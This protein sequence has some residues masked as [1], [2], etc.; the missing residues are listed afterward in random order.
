MTIEF[1]NFANF[2]VRNF[3]VIWEAPICL[4]ADSPGCGK[5]NR[6]TQRCQTHTRAYS[7]ETALVFVGKQPMKGASPP[8]ECK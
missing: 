2:I 7:K 1:G 6:R 4:H 8:R 5:K 3:V